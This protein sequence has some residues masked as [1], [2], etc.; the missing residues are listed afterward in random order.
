MPPSNDHLKLIL[1]RYDTY[2][3]GSNTKAAFLLAF[4]TFLC[5]GI[6]SNYEKII[7]LVTVTHQPPLNIA[8]L[9]VFIAGLISLVI[10]LRAMYPY[11]DSGNSSKGKYHSLIF[12]KSVSEFG[13]AE[14]YADKL[15]EQTDDEC[16]DDLAKQ[17]F[18]V[19][20]G[21]KKKYQ[22]IEYATTTI[23]VQLVLIL[24]LVGVIIC[25][26]L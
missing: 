20:K 16:W 18:A 15:R 17:I 7:G 9:L 4:N 12:F 1:Q 8:L 23:Y 14:E 6:L 21:L 24:L 5:G 3:T 26:K 25:D 22:F 11:M 2:I 13:T 19:G 10:V